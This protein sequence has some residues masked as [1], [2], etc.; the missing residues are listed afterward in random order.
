LDKVHALGAPRLRIRNLVVPKISNFFFMWLNF[1]T[2]NFIKLNI[3]FWF[4]LTIQHE[5][6]KLVLWVQ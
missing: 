4:Y 3:I 2:T 6:V 5:C 1:Y